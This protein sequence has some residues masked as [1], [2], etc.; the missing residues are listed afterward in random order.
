MAAGVRSLQ[1][2]FTRL[3]SV[4]G[5]MQ[6]LEDLCVGGCKSLEDDWLPESSRR[7]VRTLDARFTRLT[8]VPE[9]LTALQE[10]G[11]RLSAPDR[12][13]CQQRSAAV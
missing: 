6:A 5:G 13:G 4:P 9:G 10:L 7:H 2:S 8:H 1:V 12:I 11:L 3:S